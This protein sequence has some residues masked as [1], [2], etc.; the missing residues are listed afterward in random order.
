VATVAT[1]QARVGDVG[2]GGEA[3]AVRAVDRP[4]EA[5]H[6]VAVLDLAGSHEGRAR[7]CLLRDADVLG[8][9][10]TSVHGGHRVAEPRVGGEA[11][12]QEVGPPTP[13]PTAPRWW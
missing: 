12:L 11:A 5:H 10:V 3:G 7:Q 8:E 2:A 6:A 1:V 13:K 9:G 4:R